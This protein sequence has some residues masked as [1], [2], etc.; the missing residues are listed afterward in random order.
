M[1]KDMINLEKGLTSFN[2]YQE[3]GRQHPYI[4]VT[5]AEMMEKELETLQAQYDAWEQQAEKF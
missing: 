2:A 3:Q 5:K 4:S 1:L